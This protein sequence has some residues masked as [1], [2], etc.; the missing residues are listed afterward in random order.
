MNQQDW[1]MHMKLESWDDL[2]CNDQVFCWSCGK[3]LFSIDEIAQRICQ[4]CKISSKKILE[5][6]TFF[7][8]A[9]GK[10]LGE[11]SE[12]AQGLCHHCKASIIRKIYTPAKKIVPSVTRQ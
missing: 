2:E 11:M 12:I 10:K 6:E 4:G 5:D 7:C 3:Q 9:C 1:W 8:W